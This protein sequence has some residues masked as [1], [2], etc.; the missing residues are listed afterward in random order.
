MMETG[1]AQ[2]FERRRRHRRAPGRRSSRVRTRWSRP[3]TTPRIPTAATRCSRF[4]P[5]RIRTAGGCCCR[6]W[7]RPKST[8]SSP[9]CR[10]MSAARAVY[11][12]SLYQIEL[13]DRMYGAFGARTLYVADRQ[14]DDPLRAWAEMRAEVILRD[15]GGD[16]LDAPVRDRLRT[17]AHRRSAGARAAEGRHH[18]HHGRRRPLRRDVLPGDRAWPVAGAAAG[19]W[20]RPGPGPDADGPAGCLDRRVARRRRGRPPAGSDGGRGDRRPRPSDPGRVSAAP[21]R[22]AERRHVPGAAADL[23]PAAP[24]PPARRSQAPTSHIDLAPT[25]LALLGAARCRRPDARRPGLA[26]DRAA[27][28][29]TCWRRPTAAPTASSRTAAST[30]IRPC[31]GRSTPATA[32]P[33]SD[34]RPGPARR[35]ASSPFVVEGLE[36]ASDGQHALATRLRSRYSP[37]TG[38]ASVRAPRPG[39]RR[40]NHGTRLPCLGWAAPTV[41]VVLCRQHPGITCA[42]ER[43][44]PK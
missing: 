24:C 15:L 17:R 36:Q 16:R 43:M 2:A 23:R 4:S 28:A 31:P 44:H 12:P 19:R 41:R 38:P 10:P 27:I 37:P 20:R 14:H 34:A 5:A 8:G 33:S 26:A 18:P 35:S 13:D 25:L 30:C 39:C 40:H 42:L 3:G 11:L 21:G 1:P 32:S 6:T 7:R 9:G 29:S 22:L